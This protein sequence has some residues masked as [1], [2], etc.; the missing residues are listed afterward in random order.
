MVQPNI[1]EKYPSKFEGG[2]SKIRLIPLRKNHD[3]FS[4]AI[5]SWKFHKY[6]DISLNAV[7]LYFILQ[8]TL[9]RE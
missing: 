3:W 1:T 8:S 9:S 6:L 2:K 7:D 4:R 5:S